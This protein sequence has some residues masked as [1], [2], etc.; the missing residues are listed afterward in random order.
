[1]VILNGN[2][3]SNFQDDI[4]TEKMSEISIYTRVKCLKTTKQHKIPKTHA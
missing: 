2:S 1:M 3:Q 4:I